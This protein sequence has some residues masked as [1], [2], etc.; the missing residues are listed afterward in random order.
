MI[1]QLVPYPRI[2]ASY[3]QPSTAVGDAANIMVGGR[4]REM[5][6]RQISGDTG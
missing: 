1:E 6:P 5:L 4:E 2:G 3:E